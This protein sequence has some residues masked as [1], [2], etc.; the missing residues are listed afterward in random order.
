MAAAGRACDC[1]ARSSPNGSQLRRP[2]ALLCRSRLP[3]AANDAGFIQKR[4]ACN[5]SG[6][7]PRASAWVGAPSGAVPAM[8]EGLA[9]APLGKLTSQLVVPLVGDAR[10]G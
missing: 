7:R 1:H 5:A 8:G 9:T 3:V 2:L 6:P 4:R 10:G